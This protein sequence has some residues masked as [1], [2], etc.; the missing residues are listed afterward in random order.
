MKIVLFAL[1]ISLY[2]TCVYNLCRLQQNCDMKDIFD[3][4]ICF[5]KP[6]DNTPPKNLEDPENICPEYTGQLACC[7][8]LQT[9]LMKENFKAIDSVFGGKFG[10][11]DICAINLKRFWCYFT[12]HPEQEKFS[13][14][15]D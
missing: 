4:K 10:G 14:L 8:N 9:Q 11:C 6:A 1:T 12:C 13:K 15:I 5:P 7:N 3:R 2:F